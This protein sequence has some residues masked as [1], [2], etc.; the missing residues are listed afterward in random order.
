MTDQRPPY[1][2]DLGDQ[3]IVAQKGVANLQPTLDSSSTDSKTT[4]FR[5]ELF[6]L[7]RSVRREWWFSCAI[8]MVKLILRLVP[9]NG[10]ARVLSTVVQ[11]PESAAKSVRWDAPGWKLLSG[12]GLD[13]DDL[14][15]T[16]SL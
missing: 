11:F 5:G 7:E 4:V 9:R 2:L 6:T 8:E 15:S 13:A 10:E 12:P 1:P 16:I 3:P 14:E